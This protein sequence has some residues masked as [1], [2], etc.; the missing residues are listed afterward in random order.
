MFLSARSKAN[1]VVPL[2]TILDIVQVHRLK[3]TAAVFREHT[4]QCLRVLF[5]EEDSRAARQGLQPSCQLQ[6]HL[7]HQV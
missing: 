5:Y 6:A 1:D 4:G 7:H 2:Y 3:Y